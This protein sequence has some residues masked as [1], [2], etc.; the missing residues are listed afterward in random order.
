VE[1]WGCAGFWCGVCI[2]AHFWIIRDTRQHGTLMWQNLAWVTWCWLG[3]DMAHGDDMENSHKGA[4]EC[5]E[6]NK[7]MHHLIFEKS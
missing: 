1:I 5:V 2:P 7:I 4:N 3:I 6:C